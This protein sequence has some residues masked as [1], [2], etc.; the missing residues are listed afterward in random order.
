MIDDPVARELAGVPGQCRRQHGRVGDPHGAFDRRQKQS[1][2]SASI[3]DAAGR[4]VVQGLA[5]P[6]HLGATMPALAGAAILRR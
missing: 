4:M 1:R 2:F 3:C 6:V 5:L